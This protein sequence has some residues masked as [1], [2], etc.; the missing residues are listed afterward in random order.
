MLYFFYNSQSF[1]LGVMSNDSDVYETLLAKSLAIFKRNTIPFMLMGA[2]GIIALV[3][4]L[5]IIFAISVSTI[6]RKKYFHI[7]LH[8]AIADALVGISYIIVTFRRIN[9]LR[10]GQ[11]QVRSVRRT[12]VC[13]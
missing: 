6:K 7:S 12:A 1:F 13:Q 3:T 2:I 8:L 10:L 4:N 5:I 9:V 11:G